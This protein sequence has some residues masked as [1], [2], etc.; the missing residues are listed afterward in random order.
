MGFNSGFKGLVI[1]TPMKT[2]QRNL[3][4]STFVVWEMWRHHNMCWKWPPF[5]SRQDWTRSA[6]FWKVLAAS[7]QRDF[8]PRASPIWRRLIISYGDIWKGEFTKTNHKPD[9]FK[10]NITE[11]IQAVTADVLA[12][13]FQNI[14]RWVQSCLDANGGH[15]Q[16]MLCCHHISYTMR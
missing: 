10:A 15:F 14:V 2:L 3:N 6:I 1:L 7:F 11:E 13:T 5:A 4:R 16:H 9:A 8:D 12:R